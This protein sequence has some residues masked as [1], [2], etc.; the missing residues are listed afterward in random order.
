MTIVTAF[1]DIKREEL[2]DFTRDNEK[3]FEYFSFWAGLKNKL[4]V[5]TSAEFKEK[6]LN[7]RAKFGLENSTV[8]I[9][10]ELES[11]DE[12]GLSLMKTTFENYD[13]SLN[14]A[15]PD[16][17][18]CK[19]YL[20]CYIMYI[21]PFCV[22]DAIKRG[23]CDE[24]IIWLDFGFNHGSDYFTNSSQFNFK[25]ESKDSLN[26]D[27]INFFS[28]KDKEETSV[29]NVYF[30]MQTYIMGG[31]L[32]AKKEHWDIFKEDM[33]EALRAFVSFNIVDDDQVMFL[34]ILRKYPQRYSV[35]KT[36]FWF[37]SLLY[38]VPDDIAKTLSIRGVQKYKLIKAKM[39]EDLK[40]RAYLS[41][42]KAFFY[43]LYFKFINKKEEK[44]C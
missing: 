19:S 40:K 18:E 14:R 41:F 29:A 13:Q 21:K 7:I 2:D 16:N 20:Y 31:L 22:C 8:V 6:I 1:Y 23:L 30:S 11:F 42:F 35:H 36:K 39:K 10:K 44:L 37:D 25:L 32:Y 9:T 34:W 26:K 24:E 15:Y 33:K 27:K 12:E 28:V 38:F 17:I 5:Y 43:Y 4:I 3:Y